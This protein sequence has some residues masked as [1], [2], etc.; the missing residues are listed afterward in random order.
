MEWALVANSES[1]T[2]E[3]KNKCYMLSTENLQ[4]S[5]C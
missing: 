4:R 5:R 1:E 3:E 2:E